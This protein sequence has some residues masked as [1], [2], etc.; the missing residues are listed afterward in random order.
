MSCG[1]EGWKV[2]STLQYDPISRSRCTTPAI[3]AVPLYRKPTPAGGGSFFPQ[4]HFSCFTLSL[5]AQPPASKHTSYPLTYFL[6]H[7]N[8]LV[9]KH[10]QFLLENSPQFLARKWVLVHFLFFCKFPENLCQN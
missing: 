10:L 3:V 7:D 5:T 1:E 9:L 4:F 6:T 2:F 8:I